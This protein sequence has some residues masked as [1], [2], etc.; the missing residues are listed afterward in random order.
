M[1]D[2]QMRGALV[3]CGFSNQT[4]NFLIAQGFSCPAD[5]LLV[6][7]S[8]IDVM[9]RN[10][11]RN[12]PD[13][14]QFPFL[15]VRKL[16]AFRFW[17]EERNRTGEDLLSASF[18][19]AAV[20]EYTHKLRNDEHEMDAAKSQDPSKPEAL[21]AT[22]DWMKWFEKF[23]NYL[24]QIRGAARIPLTYI[25]RNH[26]EVNDN[27]RDAEYRSTLECLI[28]ITCLN[29]MHFEID[30]KRVWQ[31]VKALVID[32]F[33]WSYIEQFEQLSDC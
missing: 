23:K 27:L 31:E 7:D 12:M 16:H 29:R 2:V 6:K 4:S 33:G 9:I 28:S 3:C 11:S 10:S 15:A 25:I 5:L 8:D 26:L 24:G 14:V 32:G 22:K 20:T 21:K 18:N 1:V 19:D 13:N 30:N 17:V